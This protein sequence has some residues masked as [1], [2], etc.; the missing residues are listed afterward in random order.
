[1]MSNRIIVHQYAIEGRGRSRSREGR[2]RGDGSPEDS[3]S[4][5]LHNLDRGKYKGRDEHNSKMEYRHSEGGASTRRAST[6]WRSGRDVESDHAKWSHDMYDESR[7]DVGGLREE[8]LNRKA[9][10][11][12]GQGRPK[13]WHLLDSERLLAYSHLFSAPYTSCTYCRIVPRI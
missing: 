2:R 6:T 7:G 11:E 1:M 10:R 13:V 3:S 9:R 8:S 5:R 4:R 12:S